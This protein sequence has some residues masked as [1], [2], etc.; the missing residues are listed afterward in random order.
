MDDPCTCHPAA[1]LPPETAER[2]AAIFSALSDPTRV[3]LIAAL[4]EGECCVGALASALG[5]SVSAIS[6]QLGLLR[7]LRVVRVR[8]A[9]RYIFYSLDDEHVTTMYRCGLEHVSHG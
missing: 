6:H 4:S 8:R 1:D 5:M 2:L 7:Q 3:R 9:G